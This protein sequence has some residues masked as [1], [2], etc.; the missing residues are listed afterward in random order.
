MQSISI[1]IPA[2][3][4]ET[5]LMQIL[6][7]LRKY[8]PD[9][10]VLV[11]NDGSTDKTAEIAA[12]LGARVI[13]HPFSMGNGAA[14]KTGAR[15]A[16]GK[17]ICFMDADGQ[18]RPEDIPALMES[19]E[20]GFDM[21]VGARVK[22]GQACALRGLGN[23]FYNWFSSLIV[24]HQIE[25]L[26]SG[27]RL[28]KAAKFREFLSLLPNKFSYPTTVTMAFFRAG[29]SVG[30][31]PI[32]APARLGESH[33]NVWRDGIRFLLIIFKIGTLYS[34]LKIFLPVAFVQ[35][36]LGLGYYLFTFVT[37]GRFNNMS[38]LMFTSA[39]TVFLI[40]LVSE[41]ITSLAFKGTGNIGD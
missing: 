13:S 38:A 22:S 25:D 30:Y 26:T 41:Q 40:G 16:S 4:E 12:E 24:G 29:Y 19:L 14:I 31:V 36:L 17:L 9:S 39:V 21:V 27:F 33:L 32:I 18:H 20:K 37:D 3:N 34:P 8:L 1:V 7:E 15:N 11:V 23:R 6:P 2:K 28:V 35:F 10:E 5:G